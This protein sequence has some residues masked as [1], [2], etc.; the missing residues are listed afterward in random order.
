MKQYPTSFRMLIS[1]DVRD[2]AGGKQ[3]LVGVYGGDDIGF[4]R[5]ANVEASTRP[6]LPQLCIYTVFSDGEG[7]FSTRVELITPSGIKLAAVGPFI[8]EKIQGKNM[9]VSCKVTPIVFPENGAYTINLALDDKVYSHKI[10]VL[11]AVAA[12]AAA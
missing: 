12:Q 10:V 6:S 11:E 9:I 3:T 4:T 1:D 7:E 5:P 2:E 8:A